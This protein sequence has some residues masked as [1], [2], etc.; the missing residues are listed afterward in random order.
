MTNMKNVL[1]ALALVA[2]LATTAAAQGSEGGGPGGLG[3]GL[4]GAS[5]L[6]NASGNVSIINPAGGSVTISQAIAQALG[7]VLSNSSTPEQRAALATAIGAGGQGLVN[8]LVALAGN[9]SSAT[10]VNAVNAYN[11]A[12][13]GV[14]AGGTP[15]PALLA[16]RQALAAM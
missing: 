6:L 1:S 15:A 4:G 10:L 3:G 5:A 8:A 2:A 16:A 13:D 11:S 12:V 7:A 14:P 9:P